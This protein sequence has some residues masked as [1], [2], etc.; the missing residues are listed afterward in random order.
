MGHSAQ[1]QAAVVVK[2]LEVQAEKMREQ[3]SILRKAGWLDI[4]EQVVAQR[5]RLLGA[6]AALRNLKS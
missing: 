2:D 5:E 6:I 3:A 4:A 1:F